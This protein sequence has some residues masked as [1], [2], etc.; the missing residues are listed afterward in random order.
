[1][2][3]LVIGGSASGKSEYA[4]RHVLSLSTP[5]KTSPQFGNRI[6]IAT[7]QPF[8]EDARARIARPGRASRATMLCAGT[9]D[10]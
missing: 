7:M 2:F 6:Y 5:E 10:L 3:T 1:M 9:V 8:G 4:E